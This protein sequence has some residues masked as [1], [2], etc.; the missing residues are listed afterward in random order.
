MFK[1]H[2]KRLLELEIGKKMRKVIPYLVSVKYV[3]MLEKDWLLYQIKNGQNCFVEQ[4]VGLEQ[5]EFIPFHST[6]MIILAKL[7]TQKLFLYLEI[8]LLVKLMRP[9]IVD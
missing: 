1:Y 5:M 9:P 4:T 7:K 8:H 2:L 6:D 3:F